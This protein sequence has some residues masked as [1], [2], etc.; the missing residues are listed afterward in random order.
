MELSSLLNVMERVLD[1]SHAA[2]FTTV[3]ADGRPHSR[4]MVPAVIRGQSGSLYAVTSPHFPKIDQ[5]AAHDR[6][7]WLFQSKALDEILEVTGKALIIDNPALKSD[8]LEA[9]GPNLSTFW[10]INPDESDLTVIETVIESVTYLQPQK[11]ERTT[12]TA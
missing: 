7:S 2:V 9:L 12:A 3:D 8:V 10:H 4:W 1:S 5:I 11:G 6:V